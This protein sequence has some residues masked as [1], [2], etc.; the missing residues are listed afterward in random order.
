MKN[1]LL[2]FCAFCLSLNLFSQQRGDIVFFDFLQ[3]Y[4]ADS[5]SVELQQF[6]R[7]TP[8]FL[9]IEYDFKVHRV[10]YYTQDVNPDSLTTATSLVTIPTNYPCTELGIMVFGHGLCL[11]DWEVPSYNQPNNAY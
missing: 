10:A 1:L 2:A 11:K 8:S 7:I 3:E 9:G 5:F 4:T 6:F